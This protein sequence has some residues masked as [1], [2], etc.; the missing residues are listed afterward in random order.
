MKLRKKLF[1]TAFMPMLLVLLAGG[2]ALWQS[3]KALQEFHGADHRY[4]VSTRMA[5]QMQ[6]AL[7]EQM[8]QW[9]KLRIAGSSGELSRHRLLF[10]RLNEK[11]DF[12]ASALAA[13][14]GDS[15][16]KERVVDFLALHRV[17]VK[18]CLKALETPVARAAEPGLAEQRISALVQKES[19]LLES[20]AALIYDE[21]E[22]YAQKVMQEAGQ[23]SLYIFLG[24]WVIFLSAAMFWLAALK[25]ILLA[26]IGRLSVY[27]DKLAAG[28]YEQS[29]ALA[30]DDELGSL[31]MTLNHASE[32]VKSLVVKLKTAK[33]R[34]RNLLQGIDAVIWEL[35]TQTN[36]YTFVNQRAQELLGYPLSSWLEQPGFLQKYCHPDDLAACLEKNRETLEGSSSGEYTCRALSANGTIV[37]LNNRIKVIRDEQG[38]ATS[39]LGVAVD[40][41]R[42]KHYEDKMAYLSNYNELTGL[43]NRT[44]LSDRLERA[45]AHARDKG[46]MTALLLVNIDRFKLINES[47][48]HKLGDE[49]I[50]S[51]AQR[52][53]TII[54]AEDTLGHLGADEFALVL[55]DVTKLEEAAE[56]ARDVLR[57]VS[58]PLKI[59]EHTLV[60]NCSVGVS[61]YPKD[62]MNGSALLKNAGSALTRVKRREKNNFMF[63]TEDMNAMALYSL[64]LENKMR[65]AIKNR[66]FILYYQP[67]TNISQ[68]RMTGVEALIRWFPP[69]EPMVSPMNFIPLAEET[70]LILPLGEWVLWEACRQ[71]KAWQDQGFAPFCM[72]VNISASQFAQPNIIELVVS[73]L[74]ETKLEARYLELE[75]T[76]SV[77]MQDMELVI[78]N[79]E[80]L[81]ELGVK[82]AI[83]DF[84]T[85]YSSLSYLKRL[86]I[87][88]LKIDKSFVQDIAVDCDDE[89]IVAAIISMAHNLKMSVIAEGV[90]TEAQLHYLRDKGCDEVQGY[91]YSKPLS[92][93][94]LESYIAVK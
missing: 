56:I 85:G 77:M 54:G 59:E 40:I 52:M 26:P 67:Q 79:L 60:T 25:K 53:Q 71:N 48:G 20:A 58:L 62:G 38:R 33:A 17:M 55:R 43:A 75:I 41:T 51:I 73:V 2:L 81:H 65:G 34:Y 37:W 47:L 91:Y 24:M 87:D 21:A 74:A 44:L 70:K 69:G 6:T 46:N 49:V 29:M 30:S 18:A 7:K 63:Y 68:S 31:A 42:M 1:L 80:R 93:A 89:A 86:P 78:K 64:Q 8:Q 11:I 4:A 32:K 16:A 36:R 9:D 90:E 94:L 14:L 39:L 88:K 84:G 57:W 19:D 83:D 45:I 13:T 35:D 10:M 50:K 76:E 5:A 72:A 15:G 82:L 61:I 66:E 27:A 12:D 28:D 3:N 22:A 23:A 92:A